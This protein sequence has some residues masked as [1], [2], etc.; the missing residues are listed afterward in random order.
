[1]QLLDNS[2]EWSKLPGIGITFK[3][4]NSLTDI[5]KRF[6]FLGD[7]F[8]LWYL[9]A[10]V[11]IFTTFYLQNKMK[12]R[13]PFNL[14]HSLAAW[15]FGLSLFSLI[16]T[17]RLVPELIHTLIVKGFVGTICNASG[18]HEDARI[19]YWIYAFALSKIVEFGDTLFVILK[20]RQLI[21]LHW[22]HHAVTFLYSFYCLGIY[23]P[24]Y[25]R[26]FVAINAAIHTVM[27]AYYG[28][29]ALGY[30]F[31]KQVNISITTSQVTQMAFGMMINIIALNYRRNNP[32]CD[33]HPN[34][35][36]AGILL[37]SSLFILFANFFVNT[38]LLSSSSDKQQSSTSLPSLT[39]K[40]KIK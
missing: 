35:S 16:V 11:Y 22:Y 14:R 29:R 28:A 15:N 33:A 37:Y 39:T 12:P 20:K 13:K 10:A 32:K 7:N 2:R 40:V 6:K 5:D 4:E 38:Y 21:F 27:Y 34:P 23:F 9:L 30:R 3:F 36:I 26:W 25:T 24:A 1:M 17:V 18:M 31:S 19:K 8:R